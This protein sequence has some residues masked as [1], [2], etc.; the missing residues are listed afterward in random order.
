MREGEGIEAEENGGGTPEKVTVAK[1]VKGSMIAAYNKARVF[2]EDAPG[3]DAAKLR[4]QV[5][6]Y[7]S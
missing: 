5:R 6:A 3:K 4:A 2:D 1:S 7:I